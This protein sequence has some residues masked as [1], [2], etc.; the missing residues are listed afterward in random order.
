MKIINFKTFTEALKPSQFR[1]FVQAFNKERYAEI[2]KKYD[3][4]KNHYRIY[5]PLKGETIVNN[6]GTEKEVTNYLVN[7]GY[8]VIDYVKGICKF[9]D[10]KNPSKIGQVLTKLGTKDNDAKR[11]MKSFV[12]DENRKAGSKEQLMVVISR[13]PYDIAGADTD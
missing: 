8:E 13:H 1:R 11:L 2:F 7:A 9:K 4:D 6:T 12:E 3:G 10:A 5:L